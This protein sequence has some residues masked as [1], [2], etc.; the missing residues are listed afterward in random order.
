MATAAAI[1]SRAL[2]LIR[3]LDPAE[4]LEE[5]DFTTGRDSLNAMLTRWE[6]NGITLG[7]QPITTPSDTLSVP[8]EAEEA[9]VYNLALKLRP[10]YSATLEPDVLKTAND[11]LAALMRDV[12]VSTP[13]GQIT[14]APCGSLISRTGT[15]WN[16]DTDSPY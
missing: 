4:A 10:E 2:R 3:V 5:Y 11:G 8:L 1:I 16:I 6:A 15:Y 12:Y 14:S 9:V 7:F 13:V